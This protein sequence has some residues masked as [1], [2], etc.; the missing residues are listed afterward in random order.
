MRCRHSAR[1][2]SAISVTA[3][4]W[5]SVADTSSGQVS[6]YR[7]L[8]VWLQARGS[9]FGAERFSEQLRRTRHRLDR[10]GR[11]RPGELLDGSSVPAGALPA[12][13]QPLGQL[14]RPLRRVGTPSGRLAEPG[15]Q[16]ALH[17]RRASVHL[18]TTRRGPTD[19]L[20]ELAHA[21]RGEEAASERRRG[22]AAR[23]RV[24]RVSTNP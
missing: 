12:P 22:E 11:H 17:R 3:S 5:R 20:V 6:R 13:G 16:D 4:S 18:L 15:P 19:L 21:R 9:S 24:D 10:T 23:D 8:Q 14:P 1:V 7:P 2:C